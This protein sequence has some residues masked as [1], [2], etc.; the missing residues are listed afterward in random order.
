MLELPTFLACIGKG[1]PSACYWD[2]D[3]THDVLWCLHLVATCGFLYSITS[4][5]I[6]WSDIIQQK[7]GNVFFSR[8]PLDW[9]K[10]FFRAAWLSYCLCVVVTMVAVMI[11][12]CSHEGSTAHAHSHEIGAVAYCIWPIVLLLIT[13]GC[14]LSGWRL[15]QHVLR[16]QM[17]KS[18]LGKVLFNVNATLLLI[19][20]S[21]AVRALLLLS[22][23]SPMPE[24]YADQF[25]STYH[26]CIWVPVTQ[27]LPYWFCSCCLVEQMRHRGTGRGGQHSTSNADQLEL[28]GG[29]R[30]VSMESCASEGPGTWV[31]GGS[32]DGGKGV[33]G[34]NLS[35]LL[36]LGGAGGGDGQQ[37]Q[38]EREPQDPH[39]GRGC[40][41]GELGEDDYFGLA[42]PRNS[43]EPGVGHGVLPPGGGVVDNFFTTSALHARDNNGNGGGDTGGLRS[44]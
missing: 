34:F 26:Y 38:Q 30:A 28:Q 6:L 43:L 2:E 35:H 19:C 11:E 3:G 16:V 32:L 15:Q 4:T 42:S 37:Q 25:A 12:E 27:W 5:A 9:T 10:V 8:S 41:Q 7:D 20:S 31:K 33:G 18:A 29:L 44:S 14:F 24:L 23:Y 39:E 21:Y 17:D 36:G 40:S 13:S 1:G 22:L